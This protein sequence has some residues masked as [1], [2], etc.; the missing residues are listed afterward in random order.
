MIDLDDWWVGWTMVTEKGF[1]PALVRGFMLFPTHKETKA[2]YK[3][4]GVPVCLAIT[5]ATAIN[6][7]EGEGL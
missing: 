1:K 3:R 2:Y 4:A 6:F 5:K 7:K